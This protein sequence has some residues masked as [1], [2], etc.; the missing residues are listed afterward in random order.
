MNG[1]LVKGELVKK[2]NDEVLS[3]Q[4][5]KHRAMLKKGVR[6][7]NAPTKCGY[8]MKPHN[9]DD[10]G[11]FFGFVVHHIRYD[12]EFVMFV[13]VECHEE[14]HRKSVKEFIQYN[15]GDSRVLYEQKTHG[16][17]LA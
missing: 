9:V 15:E 12:S 5:Q 17:V 10:D 6:V 2:Y 8:C 7:L 14:I 1:F 16:G 3:I 4:K 11:K 13:H